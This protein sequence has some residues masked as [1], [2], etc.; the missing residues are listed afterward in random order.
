MVMNWGL[1]LSFTAYLLDKAS[2][3]GFYNLLFLLK[4]GQA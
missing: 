3:G 4:L 2:A 1:S